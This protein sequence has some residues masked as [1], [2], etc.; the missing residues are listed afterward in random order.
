MQN[1]LIK[2]NLI[3]D[4]IKIIEHGENDN[5]HKKYESFN[6]NTLFQSEL[7]EFMYSVENRI[8]TSIPISEGGKSL[9]MAIAIH[10]S[11]RTNQIIQL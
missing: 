5:Y 9:N 1:A 10:K 7:K 11:L 8:P 6:R 4:E 3:A 2:C